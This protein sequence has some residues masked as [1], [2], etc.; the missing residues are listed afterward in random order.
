MHRVPT[1]FLTLLAV[2]LLGTGCATSGPRPLAWD[3]LP[4]ARDSDW[5]AWNGLA[6]S[7]EGGDLI[8][9]GH[10][11]RTHEAYS[12][13]LTIECVVELE[14]RVGNDG[15]FGVGFVPTGQPG[16]TGPVNHRFLQI[17][18]RG[19]GVSD[20]RDSLA[21][22]ARDNNVRDTILWGEEPFVVQAR[23]PYAIRVEVTEDQVRVVIDDHAYDL[24]GVK[25]PY[26]RFYIQLYSW[27]PTNR[28]H[29]RKFSI[30]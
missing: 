7:L 5:P 8:L 22:L 15:L 13:P 20:G 30:H 14:G 10:S 24:K 17:A 28:W 9:Q 18:Y 3:V 4:F 27:Q 11:V 16:D 12:S 29:V 23:K 26:K 21:F 6:A 25:I 1:T 2:T 19:A